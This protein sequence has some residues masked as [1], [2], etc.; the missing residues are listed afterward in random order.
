M[1]GWGGGEYLGVGSR[2]IMWSPVELRIPGSVFKIS[3]GAYHSA[4]ITWEETGKV[5]CWGEGLQGQLGNGSFSNSLYLCDVIVHENVI[6]IACGIMHTLLLTANNKVLAFGSNQFGEL[7]VGNKCNSAYPIPVSRLG[8][9]VTKIACGSHS[10]AVTELNA[11]YIW[12]SG[13]FGEFLTPTKVS[14]AGHKIEKVDI[15]GCSGAVL[16]NS[17]TI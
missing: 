3:S 9:R 1:L 13:A 17:G 6:D 2:E 4:C 7:G 12:G 15:G 10:A 14:Y 16:D 11:L 5:Y 8:D